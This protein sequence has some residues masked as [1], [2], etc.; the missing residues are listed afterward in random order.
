MD[1]SVFTEKARQP[2]DTDLRLAL[3]ATYAAW[4]HIHDDVVKKYPSAE[5]V[6]AFTSAKYGWSFRMK[7]RK[8]AILYLLP[9]QSYF[10]V[11]FVFGQKAFDAVLG[12]AAISAD[13]KQELASAKVYAEGRG[14]RID[15]RDETRLEDIARLIDIKLAC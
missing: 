14:I 7:D 4:T 1:T 5:R 10:K 11:A 12:S 8:R 13:I 15:I 3:G 6:W 9:R 2:S